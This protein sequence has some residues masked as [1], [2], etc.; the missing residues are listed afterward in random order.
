MPWPFLDRHDLLR[1]ADTQA[2]LLWKAKRGIQA[3][4]CIFWNITWFGSY[5]HHMNS[6]PLNW[7]FF[8]FT[9]RANANLCGKT[10]SE[11]VERFTRRTRGETK[12]RFANLKVAFEDEQKVEKDERI[13]SIVKKIEEKEKQMIR[14][15]K[16]LVKSKA[17]SVIES[18]AGTDGE[19]SKVKEI[20]Q[21]KANQSI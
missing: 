20:K 17:E 4:N 13:R 11:E 21:T 1:Q 12:R 14:Q 2:S 9:L 18:K 16:R 15:K 6:V 7:F 3:Q 19:D 10:P 8:F 5:E